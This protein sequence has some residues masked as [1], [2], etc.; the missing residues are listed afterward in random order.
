MGEKIT[1]DIEDIIE[2]LKEEKLGESFD[3]ELKRS[4]D[5]LP[6]SFWETYSSFSNTFGGYIILGVTET[7]NGIKISGV[8]GVSKIIKDMCNTANNLDKVL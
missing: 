6:K 2:Q 3:I 5:K 1:K 7:G 4:T 8:S